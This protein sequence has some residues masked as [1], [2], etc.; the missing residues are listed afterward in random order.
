[1]CLLGSWRDRVLTTIRSLPS[2]SELRADIDV[3]EYPPAPSDPSILD[4]TSAIA[5][6]VNATLVARGVSPAA[7]IW[8]GEIGPHNGKSPGCSHSSMRWA[9]WG[10]TFWYLD[11]MASKAANGY[12]GDHDATH[13]RFAHCSH[14]HR[15]SCAGLTLPL[16]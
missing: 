15:C 8:A 6:D 10:D 5:H 9:N 1:M 2:S 12:S 7:Q 3:E 16:I 14:L 13:S 11:A 4:L